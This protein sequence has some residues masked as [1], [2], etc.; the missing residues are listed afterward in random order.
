MNFD[1]MIKVDYTSRIL[2]DSF[3][4]VI[5]GSEKELKNFAKA[6]EREIPHKCGWLVRA[7]SLV[8]GRFIKGYRQL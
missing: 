2:N 4:T 3:V 8:S 1:D 7:R 6:L 5:S